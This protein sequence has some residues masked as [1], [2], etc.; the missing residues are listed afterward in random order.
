MEMPGFRFR[1][2]YATLRSTFHRFVSLHAYRP[3]ITNVLSPVSQ[4]TTAGKLTHLFASERVLRSQ[5]DTD[6]RKPHAQLRS[7]TLT[8]LLTLITL[9]SLFGIGATSAQA[10]TPA[11]QW[12]ILSV[13]NPTN[14]NPPANKSAADVIMVSAV[15]VGGASTNGSPVTIADSLP[16]GLEAVEAFGNNAYHNAIGRETEPGYNEPETGGLA[17]TFSAKAASCTSSEPIDP[18]DT[19]VVTIRVDVEPV[20]PPP[21][22]LCEVP[23]GAVNC[24]LNNATVSG[25]GAVSASIGGAGGS[26]I[27]ISSQPAPYGVASGGLIVATSTSQAGGH[28]NLTQEFFLNT[29]NRIGGALNSEPPAR[30][31][32]VRYDLPKGLLGTTVG[33]ARCTMAAVEDESNCPRDTMV[34]AATTIAE[35]PIGRI[36][37]TVP[38]Y[39]IAPAPGEPLALAFNAI[40]FP[41]RIDT[42]VLSDGEY[43]ARV[44]V[45]DITTAAPFY[46]SSVTIWGDPAEHNGRGPDNAAKTIGSVA[47]YFTFG[48]P[49][50]EEFEEGGGTS[51]KTVDEKR[52]PLLTNP[53]QCS[54]SLSTVL[55]TDSWEAPGEFGGAGTAKASSG[56]ATGCGQL[57]F[58]AGISMVPDTL[59]AGAPAGYAF[60]LTVPQNTEAE[61]LATPYVKRVSVTLPEGTVISPSAADGLGDCS[62]EQFFGPPGERHPAPGQ[63]HPATPGSCPRNSQVGEVEVQSPA[64]EKP[65]TGDVYLGAPECTGPGGVCTPE[66]AAGGNMVHLYVQL[67]GEGEDGIVVKLEGKGYVNQQTGQITTVF[68]NNPQLPFSEFKLTLQGGERATLANPRTCGQV[69]TT[70][71]LTPWSTPYTPD[72]SPE[73][74]FIIDENCF[75]AQFNPSFSFGTTSNQ[76]GGYSPFS[77]SFGRGDNDGFL[78]GI[79]VRTPPG[80]LGMLSH[81]KLCEEPQA[82][83]GTCGPESQI[84]ET[85]VETGP[86][87]D[88]F[89]VTGG[90]VYI[91]GPYKSAPYGL[92]IVVPSKAGPYTLAGTT[93]N[94]TVVV[95]SAIS[96]NP[97]TSALTVTS[98]QL[99]TELD[100]IPLQ[101]KLVNVTINRPE[102]IFNSTSCNKMAIGGTLTDTQAAGVNEASSYQ[103]T[104]CGALKFQPKFAVSTSGKTSKAKGASLDAKVS[105]GGGGGSG[106]ISSSGQGTQANIARVKVDLPKQLPSRLTTLQKACTTAVFD[107]NPANCPAASVIGTVKVSTPV[108]PVQ[109]TGPVIFVSHGGEAFPSLTIVLQGDGVRVDL[110][111]ATFISKTGITSTTFKTVPDVPFSSF[112]LYLPEGKYSALAANGNLCKSSLAMPTEFVPQNGGATIHES[113][114]IS[115]TGCPKTKQAAKKKKKAKKASKARKS[116]NGRRAQ[117]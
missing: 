61:G 70:A 75:G 59:E 10:E 5:S 17:C 23:A 36:D 53:T 62:N 28:P 115:V 47:P 40:Y 107:A 58:Q 8:P 111:G 60:G 99:P 64:L 90:K 74:P 103:V 3:D 54:E 6:R 88:P 22:P 76:A 20:L 9:L 67:V 14:F 11:P 57:S 80:L 69:H 35:S 87:A 21:S 73:S 92:S 106:G 1:T 42:S 41:V 63:E 48:G 94:G 98:D 117:S 43:N 84:G 56:T 39:N 110:T 29:I 37:F 4:K 26:P 33:V 51:N 45:P 109:L 19:L 24:L 93:G 108:L 32:D 85:S 16:A 102:F 66:D 30:T 50:V 31:K 96:V 55:E 101:L 71:D 77:V 83:Q 12:K 81:V 112:E 86:G 7:Q 114:K 15:N 52:V 104:N 113:T 116:T 2:G 82:A 97:E 100:G 72:A 89:L 49:G 44:T 105:F 65:L 91:T 27:I 25:G 79:Q 38:V 68:D 46:M 78:N 34:G 18:G 95:R 13:S